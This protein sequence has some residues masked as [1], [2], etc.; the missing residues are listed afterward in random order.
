MS[1][2]S[3]QQLEDQVSLLV[4]AYNPDIANKIS[5]GFFLELCIRN[6][7]LSF[8]I[9]FFVES[10]E[11]LALVI[12]GDNN[13]L[14]ETDF[15]RR[16]MD[17]LM[18][19]VGIFLV[20]PMIRYTYQLNVDG[21]LADPL[22][23]PYKYQETLYAFA[24]MFS[25]IYEPFNIRIWKFLIILLGFIM[26]QY[27][28]TPLTQKGYYHYYDLSETATPPPVFS[29]SSKNLP[30]GQLIHLG[31]VIPLW[32]GLLPG[33]WWYNS[34]APDMI[35]APRYMSF[36]LALVVTTML[37]HAFSVP[38]WPFGSLYAAAIPFGLVFVGWLVAMVNYRSLQY[39]M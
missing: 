5:L 32:I 28:L 9:F 25:R 24:H 36:I 33:L 14:E 34:R 15:D 13:V 20:A 10:L 17:P 22:P 38:V 4:K 27:I 37:F 12:G 8:L 31:V 3:Q 29:G 23:H 19:V 11:Y 16:V 6:K 21:T 30:I 39:E 35:S 1:T 7:I 18:G 2:V 26:S